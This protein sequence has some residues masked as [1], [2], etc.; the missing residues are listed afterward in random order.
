MKHY[1]CSVRDAKSET[2]GR[3][4]FAPSLGIAVRSFD[5]E[6]NREQPDNIMHYHPHDF[7]L[8]TLGH[9]ED[10]TGEFDTIVPKLM[11]QGSEVKKNLGADSKISKV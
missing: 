9:F 2:F 3:P 7:S 11:I 4:F 1:I 6:V 10:T 8:W 5:D